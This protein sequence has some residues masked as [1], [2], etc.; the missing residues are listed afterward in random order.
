[1]F[2][3]ELPTW[4]NNLWTQLVKGL[5]GIWHLTLEFFRIPSLVH[6]DKPIILLSVLS[7][8]R[9]NI[10]IGT[11]VKSRGPILRVT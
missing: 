10:N 4:L 11:V 8:I 6:P 2:A 9:K 1:M 3:W 7:V 5:I